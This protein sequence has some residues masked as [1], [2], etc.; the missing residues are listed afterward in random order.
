MVD[1]IDKGKTDNNSNMHGGELKL[2]RKRSDIKIQRVKRRLLKHVWIV[3]VIIIFLFFGI[4]SILIY[5]SSLLLRNYQSSSSVGFV[6]N[7]IF[8]DQKDLIRIGEKTNILIL[9][10]GGEGHETPDLTDTIIVLSIDHKDEEAVLVSIPRDTWIEDLQAKIN[11]AYYWGNQKQESGGIVLTKSVVE[12]VIGEPIQYAIVFDF[13]TFVDVIDEIDG[14][15]ISVE[16]SF[17]D[18]RYPIQGKEDD[19]CDGDPEYMCRYETISFEKGVV[20][21]D[22]GT[23]L[24]FV[25]SR[26]A[27]GDEGTDIARSKRQQ[28]VVK[29]IVE[30]ITDPRVFLS[31]ASS[32]KLYRIFIESIETDLTSR[33][34]AVVAR[35][36][37]NY[38]DNVS[39]H[40]IPEDLFT[41]PQN[42]R[43]YDGLYVFIPS[44][45]G[46]S[47][48]HTWFDKVIGN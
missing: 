32:N 39:T 33:Q 18:E 29:A 8:A 25:R 46:W 28:E 43:Q 26:N 41:V 5:S 17:V 9:G 14:V 42:S 16:N 12:E 44:G 36:L 6:N 22:G 19:M 45:E 34:L 48:I 7:F 40:S 30:K 3:R 35:V 27:E 20:V 11:S 13:E 31:Y 4:I 24:K 2:K 47:D 21:M 10:K 38:S 23:A 37:F 1:K 15:E